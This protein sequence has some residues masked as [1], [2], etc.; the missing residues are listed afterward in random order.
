MIGFALGL[1]AGLSLGEAWLK[2]NLLDYDSAKI[3]IVVPAYTKNHRPYAYSKKKPDLTVEVFCYRVN[4]KNRF[5]GY[6][7]WQDYFIIFHEGKMIENSA[8]P[9]LRFDRHCAG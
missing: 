8:G 3:E 1:A 5:G 6:T 2:D 9:S 7:G 4:S